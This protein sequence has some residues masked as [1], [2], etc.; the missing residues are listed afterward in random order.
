MKW[1]RDIITAVTLWWKQIRV[2]GTQAMQ[3]NPRRAAT[4][5]KSALSTT[6]VLLFWQ[7]PWKA[8]SLTRSP[9]YW[10]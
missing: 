2:T 8:S 6:E 7:S 9:L 10:A 1:S 3:N 4:L 5:H